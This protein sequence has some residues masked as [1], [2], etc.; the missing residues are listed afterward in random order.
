MRVC[1]LDGVDRLLRPG[2][3]E[4]SDA[5]PASALDPSS[6]VQIE[7]C[8]RITTARS[9]RRS[10]IWSR[11]STRDVAKNWAL[12]CSK[13]AP[14]RCERSCRCRDRFGAELVGSEAMPD[15]FLSYS[16]TASVIDGLGRVADLAGYL[17]DEEKATLDVESFL[18]EGDIDGNG[19]LKE[20][21][22][23]EVHRDA[24]DQ[25]HRSVGFAMRRPPRSRSFRRSKASRGGG[26]AL[27]RVDR[28]PDAGCC[29][30]TASRSSVEMRWRTI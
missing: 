29:R 2:S 18:D 23:G 8:R 25:R 7:L 11:S 28:C 1:R 14:R 15:A 9:S 19:S 21:P 5:E 16:D 20:I 27:L 13:L 17:T 10:R 30:C 6:P 22:G 24:S 4:S 12:S 26:E 3:N